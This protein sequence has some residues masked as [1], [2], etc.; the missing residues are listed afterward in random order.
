MNPVTEGQL[1]LAHAAKQILGEARHMQEHGLQD[2][3]PLLGRGKHR[4]WGSDAHGIT[5]LA[6]NPRPKLRRILV[7]VLRP[8]AFP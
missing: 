3:V 2:F 4:G 6:P 1:R 8:W 5:N 7:L